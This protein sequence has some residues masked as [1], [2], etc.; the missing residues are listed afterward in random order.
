[1]GDEMNTL[2][3]IVQYSDMMQCELCGLQW[4]T[5]DPCEPGCGLD[6]MEAKLK[7]E[8]DSKGPWTVVAGPAW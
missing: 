7:P 4:D 5:N 2:C 6:D 8:L 1:M 3:E